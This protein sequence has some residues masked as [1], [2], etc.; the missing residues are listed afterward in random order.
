MEYQRLRLSKPRPCSCSSSP[1]VASSSWYVLVRVRSTDA[2]G[3]LELSWTPGPAGEPWGDD[4]ASFVVYRSADGRSW[5]TGTNVGDVA[6]V[7][8]DADLVHDLPLIMASGS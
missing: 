7:S 2:D 3:R 6:S 5:D 8:L 1:R 4:A